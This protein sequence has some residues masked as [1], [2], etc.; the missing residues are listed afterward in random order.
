MEVIIVIF[1]IVFVI[2]WLKMYYK[3]KFVDLYFKSDMK[4]IL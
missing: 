1:K 4:S 3:F 2:D